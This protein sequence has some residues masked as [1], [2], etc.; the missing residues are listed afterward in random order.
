MESALKTLNAIIWGVPVLSLILLIGI[1][2]TIRSKFAQFRLLPAAFRQFI[3]SI[4]G[5]DSEKSG[6]RAMCTA[7]AA[8]V[9]TGNIAGVAGAIALGGPGVLFWMWI[10]A[11]LGM[12]T[13]FAEIILAVHYREKDKNG[14]YLGGPMYIIQKALPSG[15][16]FL[17][18]IYCYFGVVAALGVG[19]AAQINTVIDGI[20]RIAVSIGHPTGNMSILLIGLGIAALL[21]CIFKTGASG[22]GRIAEKVVPIASVIYICMA[23]IVLFIKIEEV[24][25][26]FHAIIKGAFTPEA[27]TGGTIGSLYLTL[28][29]GTSRGVFT[30]EA[31]MGTASIA[32]AASKVNHPVEQGLMGIIEVFLDT[33]VICTLTG[34]VILCSGVPIPYGLDPGITLTMD[35]FS[36]TLGDWSILLLT[37][38]TCVFAFATVLGWGLYGA[39]CFQYLFGMHTWKYFTIAQCIA[40]VLGA[41]LNTS[42]V[43]L[44]SEIVNGLMAIPNLL[45]LFMLSDVIITI[46]KD[47][48]MK[49]KAYRL[50]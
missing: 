15:M 33:I 35:A 28:R 21:G 44:L 25:N 10:C 5:N 42:V 18:Y 41:V 48:Y 19:N 34:L 37:A 45:I 43:W 26:A 13:K 11:F 46:L 39:R 9:G 29:V 27:V 20:K 31:G 38:L 2:L 49:E 17:G 1:F 23:V 32:H 6:Y 40:V 47:H 4:K 7:L 16:R 50:R 36:G 24:P 14:E 8:T 22:I 3:H 12:M 30:N